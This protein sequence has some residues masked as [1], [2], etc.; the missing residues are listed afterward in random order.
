[1]LILTPLYLPMSNGNDACHFCLHPC[2]FSTMKT[3]F[4]IAIFTALFAGQAIAQTNVNHPFNNGPVSVTVGTTPVN[5]YDN[6]G[7]SAEYSDNSGAL[8]VLTFTPNNPSLKIQVQFTSFVT[9]SSY[10]P[11]YVFDGPS[12]ASPKIASPN[13]EPSGAPNPWSIGGWWGT[14]APNNVAPNIVRATGPTGALTL[15]FDTDG[16]VTEPGWTAIV[17]AYCEAGYGTNNAGVVSIDS[18]SQF[19]A[20]TRPVYARIRN[21]GENIIN[22]VT[23]NWEFNGTPQAPASWSSPLDTCGGAATGTALV[24]LGNQSFP[25]GSVNA[26]EAWTSNPNGVADTVNVNDTLLLSASPGLAGTYT[27]GG[28]SPSYPTFIAAVNALTTYGVCAPVTFNVRNGTYNEQISIGQIAGADSLHQVTFQSESSDSSLAILTFSGTSGA[29]YTLRLNGSD[30][31]TF[32]ELTIE[33]T[34]TTYGRAVELTGGATHNSFLNNLLKSVV[35]TS[36][37]DSRAVVYSTSGSLNSHNLF[38]NNRLRNGSLGIHF[39]GEYNGGLLVPGTKVSGNVFENQYYQGAY[40]YRHNGLELRN[41]DV[42][43]NTAYAAY[44]GL[45]VYDAD[46]AGAQITGNRLHD[47]PA[48]GYGIYVYDGDATLAQQC[49][50]ANNYV[51]IGGSTNVAY[52]IY[53]NLG[54]YQNIL[55]NTVRLTN[56]NSA[57]RAFFTNSGTNK[58]VLNNLFVNTGGGPAVQGSTGVTTSDYNDF[59]ATG[60]VLGIWAGINQATLADWQTASSND[61][62]SLAANPQFTGASTFKIS[63][64]ELNGAGIAS[65]YV[66]TDIESEARNVTTPDIGADEFV[67][68]TVDAALTAFSSPVMPFVPGAQ[69]VTATLKNNGSGTLTSATINWKLNGALQAPYAWSGS[70]ASGATAG[71]TVGTPTLNAGTAYSLQAWSSLPN[72]VADGVPSND[73]A[74]VSNLYPALAGVYTIGGVS[75]SYATFSAAVTALHQGGVSAPVTFNVRNGTYTEQI[76]INQYPGSDS[77]RQVTFQSESGDSSLVIL[78]FAANST[79]NYTLRLNGADWM[80]FRELTL[81]ATGTTYS[82]IVE[83]ANASNH[84]EFSNNF[85]SSTVTTSTST[86][87][88]LIY[89]PNTVLNAYFHLKNSRLLNGSTGLYLQGN[90]NGN[91]YAPGAL[92]EG[93]VFENQYYQ[94]AYFNAQRTPVVRNNEVFTNSAY[95]GY[96]GMDFTNNYFGGQVTG[97][98]VHHLGHGGYGIYLSTANGSATETWLIANNFTGIG[99]TASETAY[100]FYISSGTYQNILHNTVQM[101]NAAPGSIAFYNNSGSNKTLKNNLFSNTGGGVAIQNSSGFTASDYNVFYAT[102]ATLAVW[103][104]VPQ[105]TLADW[106]TASNFDDFSLSVNPQFVALNDYKVSNIQLNAAGT[107]S[108]LVTTDIE[109]EARSLTAPDIGADEFA[110]PALDASL[111]GTVSPQAPFLAGSQ[112]VSVRLKNNGAANLTSATL[113]WT[114]NGAVQPFFSWSGSLASGDTAVA[115]LGNFT[116]N[117]GTTYDLVAWSSNPNGV[118][119]PQPS[120]DTTR[121]N[122]LYP[123]LSGTYTI[124]GTSP[125]FINFTEAVTALHNGGVVGTVTFDV[126]NGTYTEQILLRAITGAS[127]TQPVVFRSES[128]DSTAV[129]LTFSANVTNNYTLRLDGADWLTFREMTLRATNTSYAHAL[130]TFG[131]AEHNTFENNV[132]QGVATTSTSAIRTLV[133]SDDDNDHYTTFRNN[134]FLSGSDGIFWEG[135]STASREAG[136]LIENN[137][138]ENQYRSAIHPGF[139]DASIVRGNVV[140][141]NSAYTA[142]IGIVAYFCYGNHQVSGNTVTLSNGTAGI[143]IEG[144]TGTAAQRGLTANNFVQVGGAQTTFGIYLLG[145]STYQNVYHNSVHL[146]ASTVASRAFYNTGGNNLQVRNNVFHAST[147]GYAYYNSLASAIPVSDYNDLFSTGTNLGLWGSTN[148]ATLAAW[149]T[150]TAKD[151]HSV[152]LDP[153]FTSAT[154]LHATNVA[155]DGLGIPVPEVPL[156]FDGDTRDPAAPDMGADEYSTAQN[157]ASIVS[158]DSPVMPFAAGSQPIRVSLLNN[159]LAALQSAAIHWS[160]NNVAQPPYNWAGSL[161][162]GESEDSV[163]VGSFP[164][165][166]DTAYTLRV[167]ASLPNGLPDEHHANDTASVSNLYAALAGTYTIGGASPDFSSFGAATTALANGGI[168]GA[169]TFNVRNGTYSGQVVIPPITGADSTHTVTFQSESGDSSAVV[170]THASTLSTANYTLYING[171]D[172]LRLRKMTIR[173]TGATYGIVIGMT[174]GASHNILENNRIEGVNI[175]STGSN[176]SLLF[177]N[178]LDDERNVIRN[179]RFSQGSFGLYYFGVGTANLETGTVI[180]NNDFE[181]QYYMGIYLGYQDAPQLLG[182]RITSPGDSYSDYYGIYCYYCDNDLKVLKNKLFDIEEGNGIYLYECDGTSTKRGLLANNFV[183]VGD[184]GSDEDLG[185]NFYNSDFQNAFHNS[186]HVV[187]AYQYSAAFYATGGNS[188]TVKNNIFSVFDEGYAAYKSGG[189]SFLSDYNDLYSLGTNYAYW[190]GAVAADLTA[191]RSASGQD[192]HSFAVDPQFTSPSDLHVEEVDMNN[193]GT[194]IASVS[195]DMDGEPRSASTPDI[196]ADEFSLITT[197]DLSVIEILEPSHDVPF[198]EGANPVKAILKNNGI[199]EVTNASVRW[200]VNG[201][202]QPEYAWSGSLPSGLRDTVQIGTFNFPVGFGTDILAYSQN[203]N[204]APDNNPGNDTSEVTGLYPALIGAYTIG[205]AFPDF[206]GFGAAANALNNGGILGAVTFNV[207]NGIYPEQISLGEINGTSAANPIVFQSE[208]G[209]SSLV[210]MRFTGSSAN[211]YV[212]QLNGADYVTFRKMSFESLSAS[213]ANVFDLRGN[214]D[215]NSILHCRLTAVNDDDDYL[216]Y[217]D[218]SLDD[219]TLIQYCLLENGGRGVYF[220]GGGSSLPESGNLV[221]DN[222]F[223][224]QRING[225]YMRYQNSPRVERN[226]MTTPTTNG[227]FSGIYCSYCD[228]DF[229][230]LRNEISTTAG[231]CIL[232]EYCDGTAPSRASIFNNFLHAGGSGV[233]YGIYAYYGSF[234]NFYHNSIHISN[235]NASSRAFYNYYGTNKNLL[236]NV[237]ANSGGG[238]AHYVSGVSGISSSNF[239]DFYAT[240]ATLAYWEGNNLASLAVLQSASGKDLNSVSVNPLFYAP[241][242][243]HAL[244]V[245]LDGD[246]TP[247][248]AVPQDFDGQ[249]R[250]VSAPD[251]GADEFDYLDHDLGIA[252]LPLP[253]PDC[254]LGAEQVRVLIQ[255]YGGLPKSGFNVAYRLNNGAVVSENVGALTVQPGA[256][257]EYTFAATANLSAIA[258]HELRLFTQLANDL[259]HPNDTLLKMVRNYQIPGVVANML[260]SNLTQNVD[261]P[262]NFSWLPALGATRYDLYVWKQGDPVPGSPSVQDISQITYAYNT[263]AWVYGAWYNWKLVA[264]NNFCQTPGPVQTFRLR[265]LPDLVVQDVQP[266]NMPFS[267]QPIQ[268][269]WEVHNL[270]LGSTGMATWYDYVYLSADNAFQPSVDT[271]LGGFSNFTALNGSGSYSNMK[272]VTL[273]NGIQGTFY[274]IVVTDHGNSVIEG[275]NNNNTSAAALM[276]VTLTP[277]PDLFVQSFI[278]P[279]NAF[280]GTN[281]NVSWTVTNQ[282]TGAV[283]GGAYFYDYLYFSNQPTYNPNNATYLGYHY[284]NTPVVAGTSNARTKQVSIPNGIFGNYYIHVVTDRFNHVFEHAFESNNTGNSNAINIILTP[285]PDLIVQNLVSPDTVSNNQSAAVQWRVRN[286]GAT[287]ASGGF[288]NSVWLSPT[289]TFNPATATGIGTFYHAASIGAGS[290]ADLSANVTIPSNVAGKRYLFVQTD[291]NNHIF[292]YVN[293]GNNVSAKDSTFV[294]NVDL[295]VTS[296]V[297][298]DPLNSGQDA[299]VN[300][301]VKNQGA[302][303]LAA[304]NRTDRIYLSASPTLVVASATELSS[305]AYSNTLAPGESL[306]RQ[307]VVTLPNGVAGTQY[308]HVLTDAGN[309]IFENANEGNNSNYDQTSVM[310]SPWADLRVDALTGLPASTIAG[311]VQ[312]LTFTVHNYGTAAVQGV[313]G[314]WKDRIYISANP[315]WNIGNAVLLKTLDVLQPVAVGG[316]YSLTTDFILPMLGGGASS[317][318]CYI[319]VFT[320]GTNKIYEHVDEGNNTRRSDPI[321]VTSP[322]PVDFDVLAATNLPDTLLSGQS[323]NLQ[324]S[325]KNFGNSTA[326]WNYALWYDGV[327]FSADSIYDEYD[328]LFVKD[329]TKQGPLGTNETYSKNE[330]FNVPNGISGNY[331]AFLT[332]DHTELTNDGNEANNVQRIRPASF[333]TGAAKPVHIQLSPSPD[334]SVNT[335]VAPTSGISGQPVQVIWTVTN[336]GV[337]TTSGTWTDKLYL[338]TD[339]S[340]G[341][342]DITIGSKSQS[343]ILAT[344]QSYTDTLAAFIPIT[345]SGNFVLIFKTDGNNTVFELNGEGNNEFFT[346]LTTSLPMPSDLVTGNLNF[347]PMAMV[348][349]PFAVTYTL[350]NQGVNPATGTM[351]DIIYLS[352]DSAFDEMDVVFAGPLNRSINLAPSGSVTATF[353]NVTPGVPLGD[354][355]VIV[356]TDALNNIFENSETN[357]VSISIGKVMVTVQ[358]LP[359][360]VLTPDALSNEQELYYRIEIPALL[361]GE[362]MRATLDGHTALSINELYLSFGEVPTRSDHDFSFSNPFAPDQSVTIPEVQAGQYYLLAYG[363][364]THA[365]A[366][367]NQ[368]IDL[369]AE[370][371]PFQISDVDAE[372]GGNT[373]NVTLRIDGAKFTPNMELRLQD[374][375]LGSVTAHTLTFINSTRVFATFNLSGMALGLYDVA[376]EKSPAVVTLP[377]GFEIIAGGA[378]TTT[379]AGGGSGGF[380]CNI[381]NVGADHNLQQ[382]IAHPASIRVNRVAPITIQFGNDGDVDIPCPSRWL[383]SLRGAPV[384]FTVAELSEGKEELFL[385]FM[386]VGGPPGI[387]R[388]GSSSSITVYAFSS[389]AMRFVLRE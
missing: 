104:A 103:A 157:D 329:F 215:H 3:S 35:T 140:S 387:L 313:S 161:L 102:G 170:L 43:S 356:Q 349:E 244:Q 267:G 208:S 144:C 213:Y 306:A 171:A 225:V 36:T 169:V 188:S 271:Y 316:T 192:A 77:L 216:I 85:F 193:T 385:S 236:N 383:I 127:G 197:D 172:W 281:I 347:A 109:G 269:S 201:V 304:T 200:R 88:A 379:G 212:V 362:T 258:V 231:Y 219:Y 310:L 251:I 337:G 232:L 143:S 50:I 226:S 179:N 199:N 307:K 381:V 119:D 64:I 124:G 384:G 389:H 92:V 277:P 296:V 76:S 265:E 129:I 374:A 159:G 130:E 46:G 330:N 287:A 325:V 279:T 255:N 18:F 326:V 237:F 293:E 175:N 364:T 297:V 113:N 342:S 348:G 118:A 249:A 82:R 47:I 358:Q 112:P 98:K 300:W 178:G 380:F 23:V 84:L 151:A 268:V 320:D 202:I 120:N 41:N 150:G 240:G 185:I 323:A 166:V 301:T 111:V 38:Q 186:V 334:F 54:G 14:T 24:L 176:Y 86:S 266:P 371:I 235:T 100:G 336:I 37:A 78:T 286:Q 136:T 121:V 34:N 7:P 180:G 33:A 116:F 149:K 184:G 274:I 108:P 353:S 42:F 229:K 224:N 288:Q 97:N 321:S 311:T 44:F 315:A 291:V 20:G 12:T 174:N 343:R 125:D 145:G 142:Y 257:A 81:R 207:R 233:A 324:W 285:P 154:N 260:P 239:N 294:K 182:N 28:A 87:R 270:G 312:T 245:A 220:Y 153:I 327:Y 223:V 131:G 21:F 262:V 256:T 234:Q 53:S 114:M 261:P 318:V 243:L 59:F 345:A 5:Y 91:N 195:D 122:D 211:N 194:P 29:N 158:I 354:Y 101:T 278:T 17:T 105:A 227:N 228:N 9:E 376:A 128:G 252:A 298:A 382:N 247:L 264:K 40:L 308:L 107:P 173:A 162:S 2:N 94:G 68:S 328:D 123:A 218:A 147:G 292:E 26:I 339:F 31:L 238:F 250:N 375:M 56:T 309:A 139:Q 333:P 357:N 332:A 152:S 73:T 74:T 263:A 295:V 177:S 242:N 352:A 335:V 75:P 331:Y 388:P 259:N 350:G 183:H 134:R 141:T 63:G 65:P 133:F 373:G 359:L 206:A 191:W 89:S 10:D 69:P 30:W 346:Y 282:G 58:V 361:A 106:Q 344:G 45:Q 317:G 62:H 39:V 289:A 303:I 369:K 70:L 164:F 71:V 60:S 137:V 155:L 163:S 90:A 156:D 79:S 146:N 368:S 302:G 11:L 19:C 246:A 351:R 189:V 110:P 22:S 135:I 221:L 66:T 272:N 290:F 248:S 55:Y 99:G 355:F 204:G 341:G 377:D 138:F 168:I 67:P 61:P 319:Y 314:G 198:P 48:G 132:F 386:E 1:M 367:G 284:G 93:N 160:V 275:N 209:D 27:I 51:Q 167:W 196:G 217:S 280:S 15:A 276:V 378:G 13:G 338:S 49:L 365:P 8:S 148:Y 222:V 57:S 363:S 117:A 370:I 52:G 241:D 25:A 187:S 283:P 203:P 83:V 230:L 190:E 6:G 254:G 366:A 273:P 305:L 210:K 214:A 126:R 72:G 95:I 96:F 360:G 340:I 165:V 253:L 181:S 115:S 16:S 322:P 80:N 299:T 372:K 4:S 205:G 32:K